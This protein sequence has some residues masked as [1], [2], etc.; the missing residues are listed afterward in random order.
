MALLSFNHVETTILKSVGTRYFACIS[1][2]QKSFLPRKKGV[3]R[4]INKVRVK[5]MPN[6]SK[7]TKFLKKLDII[8]K[9]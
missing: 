8:R 1:K 4:E 3:P 6:L 2:D 5:I 7:V 9:K